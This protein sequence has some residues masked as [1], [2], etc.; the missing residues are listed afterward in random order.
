M[1]TIS[2]MIVTPDVEPLLRFYT[3]LFGAEQAERYPE[4]GAVFFVG[5]RIGDSHLGL[6][7][8]AAADTTV[9]Q[10]LLLSIDVEDVDKLLERVEELGGQVLGPANDMPWGQRVAHIKDPDGNAINLTQ[11]V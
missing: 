9:P 8:D 1:S 3:G 10:R 5:L 6:V 4:D 7:S 11:P 2:P